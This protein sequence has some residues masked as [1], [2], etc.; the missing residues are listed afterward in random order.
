MYQGSYLR[1]KDSDSHLFRL[2]VVNAFNW[3][4]CRVMSISSDHKQQNIYD[5]QVM[6]REGMS[7]RYEIIPAIKTYLNRSNTQYAI[8]IDGDWGTGKTYFYKTDIQPL[9]KDYH[10]IYISLYGLETIQDIENELFKS[11][12]LQ[13]DGDQKPVREVL[14][15]NSAISE[16]IRLGGSGY[17]VQVLINQ[18]KKDSKI[19]GKPFVLCLDDLER[20]Q[21]NLSVCLSY[22]NK[23]VEHQNAKCILIGNTTHFAENDIK[24]FENA[25]EKT[26]AHI[27]RL[28]N[29]VSV[30]VD[31]AFSQVSFDSEDSR[32]FIH[33]ML[34]QKHQKLSNLLHQLHF[35]NIRIISEAIQL[36]EYIYSHH[37]DSFNS[38]RKLAFYYFCSLLA[39]L[40][41]LNRYF[42]Q[43]E[44]R[45]RLLNEYDSSRGYA[46]LNELG[47]FD[48]D[49]PDHMTDE[50][51]TL[52][53]VIFYRA[54]RISLTGLFSIVKKG[55]YFALDFER[56]FDKWG[57]EKPYE[58]Y[59]DTASLYHMEDTKVAEIIDDVMHAIFIK[60]EIT[61]P[62]TLLLLAEHLSNDIQ[63]GMIKL[64][65]EQ[66]RQQFIQLFQELYRDDRIDQS[67]IYEFDANS[68]RFEH[69]GDILEKVIE[70]HNKYRKSLENSRLSNFWLELTAHPASA[71]ELFKKFKYE[72]VFSTYFNP[73]EVVDALA[74]LSNAQLF[75]IIIWMNERKSD[76]R[77]SHVLFQEQEQGYNIAE[78]ISYIYSDQYGMKAGHFKQIAR[79]LTC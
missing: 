68:H 58:T 79:I 25:R 77:C 5:M 3:M 76:P 21:G 24:T 2:R 19:N 61:N 22:I 27:Y 73:K 71:I 28:E 52:L 12:S 38:S 65:Y 33:N 8:M 26:I 44:L 35:K 36:Y 1:L 20:W 9:I 51:R 41:L 75:E 70:L 39:T 54:D 66:T 32:Q 56:D 4:K 37:A 11:I 72:P 45:A 59:L 60:K 23:L 16:D 49:P 6:L 13:Q 40:I 15:V 63:Q 43:H 14:D 7:A 46:F 50:A 62:D 29:K 74:L 42:L 34:H 67:S 18:W 53:E 57:I 48:T 69:C 64:D 31:A 10:S 30:V 17:A 78:Y 47:Y 55:F